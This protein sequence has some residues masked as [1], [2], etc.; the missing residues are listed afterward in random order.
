MLKQY[1]SHEGL[2]P[3]D[4]F[5]DQI[6]VPT[7]NRAILINN[8]AIFITTLVIT[9]IECPG[10]SICSLT[11]AISCDVRLRQAICADDNR[12]DVDAVLSA[13]NY[14]LSGLDEAS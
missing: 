8:Y 1:D 10:E 13:A 4:Q 9:P 5:F 6:I 7:P 3:L 2:T 12:S 14:I 11:R